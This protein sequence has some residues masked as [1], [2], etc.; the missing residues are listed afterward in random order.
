M[1][2]KRRNNG[3]AF[4]PHL[5]EVGGPSIGRVR[6]FSFSPG[7]GAPPLLRRRVAKPLACCIAPPAGALRPRTA[8]CRPGPAIAPTGGG[9]E[10]PP[11]QTRDHQTREPRSGH[12][13]PRRRRWRSNPGPLDYEPSSSF[14][15]LGD[16]RLRAS[17]PLGSR[18]AQT[19]RRHL[20][21]A[22]LVFARRRVSTV[23]E[24]SKMPVAPRDL[25]QRG[26]THTA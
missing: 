13:A 19:D 15:G 12:F 6:H 10:R 1:R 20:A 9:P 14:P 16:P 8:S 4:P 26:Q 23:E 5:C 11:R 25:P 7:R 18:A 22:Q 3:P 21:R 2:L 17:T 24:Q